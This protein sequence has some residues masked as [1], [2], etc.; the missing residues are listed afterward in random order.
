[1]YINT[2]LA[3][4][5]ALIGLSTLAIGPALAGEKQQFNMK[6]LLAVEKNF[7]APNQHYKKH[8]HK[9]IFGV[10]GVRYEGPKNAFFINGLF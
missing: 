5:A 8:P 10:N 9:S 7:I 1:M 6:K 4:T 3:L 2:K